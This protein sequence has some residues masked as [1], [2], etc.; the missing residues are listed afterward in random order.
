MLKEALYVTS[1]IIVISG[2]VGTLKVADV[3]LHSM[4]SAISK[5]D[6]KDMIQNSKKNPKTENN[7]SKE[8]LLKKP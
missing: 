1:S 7:T 5:S 8:N 2:C 6:H 4:H 3:P